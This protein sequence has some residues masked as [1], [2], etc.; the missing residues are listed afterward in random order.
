M[1]TPNET[2]PNFETL[3]DK[4]GKW[5]LI[6]PGWRKATTGSYYAKVRGFDL[7]VYY[8]PDMNAWNYDI[9]QNG[10]ILQSG[11]RRGYPHDR[12]AMDLAVRGYNRISQQSSRS[13][14]FVKESASE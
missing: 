10:K 14:V 2:K 13:I 5:K 8:D 6:A 1:E 11:I 7:V 4:I 3:Q 12:Q 9:Y